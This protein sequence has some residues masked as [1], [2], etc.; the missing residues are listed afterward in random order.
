MV[1]LQKLGYRPGMLRHLLRK[2]AGPGDLADVGTG[3]PHTSGPALE[4][5]GAGGGWAEGYYIHYW[6]YEWLFFCEAARWCEGVDYY[7]AAPA[8][9]RS[10]AV[11]SM[12]ESYPGI[13]T[14][15][16]RRA[17]P[18]GDGGGRTFGGDRD[19][20]LARGGSSSISSA[21]IPITR[22]CTNSMK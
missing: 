3:L 6:L 14:Y 11:A 19:R 17:V 8:F 4:L 13:G 10:R 5:A 16:S 7:A 22:P 9:Y 1:R 2:S 20:L 18:I 12:F 15:N 21:V